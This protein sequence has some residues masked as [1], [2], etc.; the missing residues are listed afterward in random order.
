M[1]AITAQPPQATTHR[2][3]L[4]IG[5][6]VIATG[7]VHFRL[8]AP[9]RGNVEVVFENNAAPVLQLHR[10]AN[11]Y[12]SGVSSDAAAGARY[13]FRLD[14]DDYLYPDPA[15]RFQPD[16]PHGP[17]Q[18][19]DPQSFQWTDGAW[20]GITPA[21]QVLYE[22]HVGT[23]TK[24]GTFAAAARQLQ[25]LKDLGITCLEVMPVADFPGKF[26]WG[27]DGVDLFAPTRLYGTPDDFR[28]FVDRAHAVGLAVI[29]DVV[30][31]HIG[32]DGNFLK[33]FSGDYF[34][35]H[36]QTDWGEAI[37]YDGPNSGPVREFFISNARYWIDEFHLDGFRFDA[38]Q[39]IYDGS[40]DHILAAVSRAARQAAG[41]RGIYLVNENEAQHTLI[42][43]RHEQGG[44]GM[45]A[46]WN[47]DFHHSAIVKLT[48]QNEAYFTD[49]LGSPQEFI[50]AAKF[51]YLYQGQRY[52]WQ[53]QRR[54]TP[55]FDLPPSAFINFIENHD[56]VANLAKGWRTHQLSSIGCY[57]AMVTMML[58]MPGTPLLFQGQEFAATAKFQ[59]FADHNPE[60][61]KLVREGRG[62]F[63]CQFPS[64][65]TP[66]MAHHLADPADP[67]TFEACKLNWSERHEGFHAEIH[68][69]YRDLLHLRHNDPVFRGHWPG[70]LDGAVLGPEAH[71]LRFFGPSGDDRLLVVNFGIDLHLDPAPEP[72]LA[73]PLGKAWAILL[74]SEHPRYGGRGT[75]P[76]ESDQNLRI[77]GRAAVVLR[78]VD[79]PLDERDAGFAREK[80]KVRKPQA[81]SQ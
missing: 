53:K 66:E 19:I 79:A 39:N 37:N 58:L 63:L 7:G 50:S 6:E 5:A 69:L 8:W 81:S 61:T 27:Y 57:R 46:L 65:A 73:P 32:P 49:Y 48:G 10:E 21:G 9:K 1:T 47:D 13:K 72:L 41:N 62:K 52:K 68:A 43:R 75:V 78:P 22:M 29:L 38:T 2:R 67:Q 51:G 64:A 28:R 24:E 31:N 55:T 74:S 14:D 76:T 54:G 18:V 34:T 77:P 60:L 56:Q 44:Y 40:K 17:S 12:F 25:E 35:D 3:R 42:V 11:G 80:Q 70:G 33:A 36:Y 71:C 30:Y 26:G 23:F 59:Y 15:S 45:D 4:P 16:G 20:K